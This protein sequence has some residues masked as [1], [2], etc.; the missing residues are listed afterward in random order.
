MP[1][2]VTQQQHQQQQSR[3]RYAFIVLIVVVLLFVLYS[4]STTSNNDNNTGIEELTGEHQKPTTAPP[5]MSNSITATAILVGQEVGG[6]VKFYQASS[7]KPVVLTFEITG[8][9]TGPHGFHI[10]EF[11]DTSNGCMSAG[12]HLN[13]FKKTHGGPTDEE[14]HMG[15]LGNIN[16]DANGVTKGELT[17]NQISMFGPYSILGRTIVV[18]ADQDDLGRGNFPDSKKTGHA[19]PRL[20]CGVIGL[21]PL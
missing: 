5:S 1:P 19:G 2:Y 11:G 3:Q 15:D 9:K 14:R 7:D 10:H 21:S 8:L 18:H 16:T 17:D 12:D 13:P 4:L 20:A 6:I